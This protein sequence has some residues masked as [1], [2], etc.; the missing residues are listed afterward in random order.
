MIDLICLKTAPIKIL[1]DIRNHTCTFIPV[2]NTSSHNHALWPSL[3]NYCVI[4]L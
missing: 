3:T 1:R 4:Q 2:R